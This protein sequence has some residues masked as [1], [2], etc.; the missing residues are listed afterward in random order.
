MEL[1]NP[2]SAFDGRLS[3][4]LS[5]MDALRGASKAAANDDAAEKLF[6]S[7]RPT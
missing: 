2:T 7:V 5:R 1:R 4:L 3:C 6:F